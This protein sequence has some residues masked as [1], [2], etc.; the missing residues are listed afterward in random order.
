MAAVAVAAGTVSKPEAKA[1]QLKGGIRMETEK[2]YK[3]LLAG[4]NQATLD[5][6][7]YAMTDDFECVT[8][9]TRSED[10]SNHIRFF[11]PDIFVYCFASEIRDEILKISSSLGE[12][13]WNDLKI[14]LVGDMDSCNEFARMK[15]ELVALTLYKPISAS[16][17]R[18]RLINY[19]REKE[20]RIRQQEEEEKERQRLE[21]EAIRKASMRQI[22]VIDDDPIMLK[23]IKQE[24]KDD[25]NVATAVNGK[26]G[27]SFLERKPVD[28]ILLDYEM[29]G[30]NGVEI[31]TKLREDEKTACIP[32]VFLTGKNDTDTIRQVLSM[33]PQGYLL[34]PIEHEKL[35]GAIEK[36]LE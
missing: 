5:D 16:S 36:V 1:E 18:T 33:K 32:V 17:I 14:V 25:Y 20:E 30:E 22:L 21:N 9:S 11:Q 34:K 19:F 26:I 6:F 28:L 24:L 10:I 13:K 35:I 4:R 29:P 3:I 12:V 15:A 7:F 27:L 31:L 23:L 2:K 8:T